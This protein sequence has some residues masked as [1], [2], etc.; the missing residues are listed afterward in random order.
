MSLKKLLSDELT[1]FYW[2]GFILADGWVTSR[3]NPNGAYINHLGIM[4]QDTDLNHLQKLIDWLELPSTNIRKRTRTTNFKKESKSVNICITDSI[5]VPLIK[6]KFD[7]NNK[8]TYFPPNMNN[9]SFTD[10]QLLALIIGFI[11]G[12]GSIDLR[13]KHC[14]H[15]SIQT[16]KEWAD[17][18]HFINT[19]IHRISGESIKNKIKINNRNHATLSI[20]KRN[21]VATL[22][23]FA[24]THNLPILARKWQIINV[25]DITSPIERDSGARYTLIDPSGQ[26][27]ENIKSL[28]KFC[29]DHG[30]NSHKFNTAI[31]TGTNICDEW[32]VFLVRSSKRKAPTYKERTLENNSIRYTTTNLKEFCRSKNLNYSKILKL[33]N[34]NIPYNN[35]RV[36]HA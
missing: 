26:V 12:D 11:D 36:I 9:Y 24:I 30:L 4:L 3:I 18:L 28:R 2:I 7:I 13:G 20:C 33:C 27:F 22:K 17:N 35:W 21:V 15:I 14:P 19:T 32:K 6:E 5:C 8:K 10:D 16:T 23:Q 34:L 1:S 31:L 25:A 29:I